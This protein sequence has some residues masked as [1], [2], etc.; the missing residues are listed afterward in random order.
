MHIVRN[1]NG[2]T[3]VARKDEPDYRC[4]K[5]FKPWWKDEVQIIDVPSFDSACPAC[6][7]QLKAATTERS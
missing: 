4:K 6:G 5:C 3:M 1:K 2:L 7:G